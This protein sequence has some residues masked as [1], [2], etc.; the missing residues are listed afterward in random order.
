M[1]RFQVRK[2][3]VE[4]DHERQ[5]IVAGE[6][7]PLAQLLEHVLERVR[8]RLDRI[9]AKRGGLALELVH[10]AEQLVD[11]LAELRFLAH[12]HLEHGVDLVQ[13]RLAVREERDKLFAVDLQDAEQ[14]VHLHR[15]VVLG[16]LE[17][18]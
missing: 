3:V 11:L 1:Q 6:P 13:L 18:A 14:H 10:L 5:E 15:A 2:Q 4:P 9:D 16:L 12:R 8:A 17:L 7:G